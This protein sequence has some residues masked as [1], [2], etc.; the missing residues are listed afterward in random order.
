MTEKILMFG[1]ILTLYLKVK[2]QFQK[3][4]TSSI[5]FDLLYSEFIFFTTCEKKQYLEKNFQ[6]LNF[7]GL[8]CLAGN[9]NLATKVQTNVRF[10]M[11]KKYILLRIFLN[12]QFQGIDII[13]IEFNYS[14]FLRIEA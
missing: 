3:E 5:C 10:T 14:Y 7:Q 11:L 1:S 9:L 8:F 13:R 2:K 12:H 4:D 6:P